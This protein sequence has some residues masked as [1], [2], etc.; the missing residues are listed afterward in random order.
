MTTHYDRRAGG[1]GD[2]KAMIERPHD[3]SSWSLGT[4]YEALANGT[5]LT[6]D[7]IYACKVPCYAGQAV[8][9]IG[10]LSSSQTP[11][12]VTAQISALHAEDGT[13]LRQSTDRGST[14]WTV[15][16]WGDFTLTSNYTFDYTGFTYVSIKITA[17]TPQSL[18]CKSFS[19]TLSGMNRTGAPT[20]RVLAGSSGTTAGTTMPALTLP[21][22]AVGS[23]PVVG[24]IRA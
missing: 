4:P 19:A 17:T 24:L 1:L 21:L 14:A 9:G 3:F 23:L 2:V 15:S 18:S 11:V 16:T 10:W 13:L 22:T 20:N 7:L 8:A 6:S 5:V 12:G